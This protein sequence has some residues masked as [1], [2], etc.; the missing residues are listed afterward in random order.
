MNK[1]TITIIIGAVL[2]IA[3]F[4]VG[5]TTGA[6][7]VKSTSSQSKF[8]QG[9]YGTRTTGGFGGRAGGGARLLPEGGPATTGQVVSETA[10]SI[11]VAIPN[12]GGSKII[13]FSPSTAII[14]TVPG[15]TSDITVGSTITIAGTPNSD[16]SVS[17]NNIQI[18]PIGGMQKQ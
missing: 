3:A 7:S 16:G 6:S 10:N 15:T 14:K 2:I 18:R 1:Q 11:T 9:M 17:A 5:R 4:F 8:T 12:N 13:L